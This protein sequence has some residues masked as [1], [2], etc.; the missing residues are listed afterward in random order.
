MEDPFVRSPS[1]LGQTSVRRL[2]HMQMKDPALTSVDRSTGLVFH[3]I[4]FGHVKFRSVRED[5]RQSE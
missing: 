1:C 3:D 2:W 4:L 5:D